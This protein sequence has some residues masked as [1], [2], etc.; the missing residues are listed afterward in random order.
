MGLVCGEFLFAT[1]LPG[2]SEVV[3]FGVL[4]LDPELLWP[5]LAVAMIGNTLG[6]VTSYLIT[7]LYRCIENL[8]GSPHR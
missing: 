4:Q 2:G 7:A 8:K 1:L 3:L 5:A 6:G